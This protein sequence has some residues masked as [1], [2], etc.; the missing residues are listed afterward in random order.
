MS[1]THADIT[2][3]VP[4]M[5]WITSANVLA[6][7]TMARTVKKVRVF[8]DVSTRYLVNNSIGVSSWPLF[9]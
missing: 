5:L 4:V 8:F 2:E 7:G 3:H 9:L 6:K 1:L